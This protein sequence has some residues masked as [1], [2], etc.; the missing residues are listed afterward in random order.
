[1]RL[2]SGPVGGCLRATLTLPTSEDDATDDSDRGGIAVDERDADADAGAD[3]DEDDVFADADADADG[4]DD[5]DDADA[6]ADAD[7]IAG[8]KEQTGVATLVSGEWPATAPPSPSLP[9][10]PPV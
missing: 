6:D 2:E 8:A 3:D 4:E 1:M 7:A 9:S 10:I 5:E